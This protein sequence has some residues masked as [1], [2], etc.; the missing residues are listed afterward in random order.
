MQIVLFE[1]SG[2][3]GLL[4]LTYWRAACELR[5]G[6][7]SL[8]DHVRACYP[9][10]SIT[11]YVRPEI[12]AVVAERTGLP[13]NIPPSSDDVLYLNARALLRG[14]LEDVRTPAAGWSGDTLV[15]ADVRGPGARKF[16]PEV[17]LNPDLLRDM[18][19]RLPAVEAEASRLALVRHPWD[20]V[21]AN[22]EMIVRD[23]E[24]LTD[25]GQHGRVYPGAHILEPVRVVIGAGSRI[26]PGVVLD[27]EE[28]PIVIG[29]DVTIQPNATVQGPCWIGDGTVV[30]TGVSVRGGTSIGPVCKIGGEI[31]GS[32]LH[33]YSNKQHDGFLGHAYV[34]E[35]VN[36]A[37]DTVN[38]DLKNTYGPVRV[39][40]NGV[41]VDS[42]QIFV[43]L[44]IGDHSKTGIG[45]L[46]PTGAVVGFGSSI[47]TSGLA[48][49]FVP[50]FRWLTDDTDEPYDVDKCLSVARIV[51]GRRNVALTAAQE[52][53]FRLIPQIAS[54][55]E[56][57]AVRNGAAVGREAGI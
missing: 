57:C 12:V 54:R 22:A 26:K 23:W 29:R 4:P 40:I 48:P 5:C 7:G 19:E 51:M 32:I 36:L 8:L 24:R 38:S 31:E 20:L 53:L 49:K 46:F 25:R 52:R 55:H 50:S 18:A 56:R 16:V 28:G 13:V 41:E 17:F 6:G 33:G 14:R 45:Q 42:G 9:E 27:A 43:G 15:W 21:H 2:F 30:Q 10:A 47:A 34:G 44:T 37:A 39:P 1:D 35:F 3:A 11:L